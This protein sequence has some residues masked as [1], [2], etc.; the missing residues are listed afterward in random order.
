MALLSDAQVGLGMP[1]LMS[2]ED[3]GL[4][5]S[6][7][8]DLLK[9]APSSVARLYSGIAGTLGDIGQAGQSIGAWGL[10]KI[11]LEDSANELRGA[12]IPMPPSTEQY[13]KGIESVTGPLHKPQTMPGKILDKAIQYSPGAIG[14]PGGLA[15]R[16][17]IGTAV[18]AVADVLASEATKGT[19]A[20]DWAGPVAALLSPFAA[21]RAAST[22]M[23]RNAR[24]GLPQ[25]AELKN[26][27]DHLYDLSEQAG[28]KIQPNS[29]KAFVYDLG[30]DLRKDRFTMIDTAPPAVAK[31]LQTLANY[32]NPQQPLTLKDVHH[33]RQSVGK[34][35]DTDD[36]VQRGLA[37][38]MYGKL[39]QYMNGLTDADFINPTGMAKYGRALQ[40]NADELHRRYKNSKQMDMIY[41][42]AN[43]R[44]ANYSMAGEA[45]GLK[46]EF[47]SLAKKIADTDSP[48]FRFFTAEERE[49]ID[50]A[51]N[52][53]LPEKFWRNL[54]K[55]V[56]WGGLQMAGYGATATAGA[57]LGGPLGALIATSIPA[58]LGISGKA[59][60][61]AL[62]KM[63]ANQAADLVRGVTPKV[64]PP[65]YPAALPGAVGLNLYNED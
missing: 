7:G 27:R 45:T 57:T 62:A 29:W 8:E 26:A 50:K 17:G 48:E 15:L 35:I 3:V 36:G 28:V 43:L 16:A 39:T 56:P 63:K 31:K 19:A 24:K 6:I 53:S 41:R 18:P 5:P 33:L 60:F 65:K 10:D 23:V 11:G 55:M 54:S 47:R 32:S 34:L 21:T 2:D 22:A 40:K 38:K 64:N 42:K 12:S 44:S 20:E 46:Q 4:M 49:A 51:A 25:T 30:T 58:G 9:T 14:G 13:T 37:L 59:I 1:S 52:A 61:S